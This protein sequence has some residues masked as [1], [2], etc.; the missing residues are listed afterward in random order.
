[1]YIGDD[2]ARRISVVD[3]EGEL[4]RFDKY[5]PA[6]IRFKSYQ[7]DKPFLE[8]LL[9]VDADPR[10]IWIELLDSEVP[11]THMRFSVYFEVVG[12]DGEVE[13]TLCS[14]QIHRR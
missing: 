9:H 1:M 13:K 3:E 11:K 2:V 10:Y 4:V 8:H 12:M 5:Q 14:G 6:V 7:D